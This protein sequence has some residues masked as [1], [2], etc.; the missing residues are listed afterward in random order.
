[1]ILLW[2][3][4]DDDPM[5][6]AH[7][8]LEKAGAEFFFLD[9]R[10]IFESEIECELGPGTSGRCTVTVGPKTIDLADV[11]AAYARGFNFYDYEEMKDQPRDHPLALKAAGFEQQLSACLNASPALVL[12]RSDP[13]ATNGSKPYQLTVIQQVGLR[14]PE[15]F[16]SNEASAVR[17]FLAENKDCIYKSI[18]G[19]RS[20]VRRV[21]ET[22][23]GFVD[24]V[25]W[26]PTLFQ[27]VVPG[28]N[29][30]VHVLNGQVFAVRIES[31]EL[32]YR[33]GQ[34]TMTPDALPMA[35]A[36]K[37]LELTAKLGLHFSGIDLMRTPNDEWYCFEVNS[38]PGYSYFERGSGMP[39]SRALAEYM[40]DADRRNRS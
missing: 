31:N 10:K 25:K 16:I 27:R 30:R 20:I 5:G 21:S 6:L 19:V 3:L 7:A 18:S 40:M 13:S 17:K 12:N 4:L 28:I 39:I 15:T 33:Y 22:H 9:H 37:C 14:I 38:S 23:L 11:R 32:D 8:A 1:M 2:G 34:T 29:Y 26:C 35:V 36:Q 24:D